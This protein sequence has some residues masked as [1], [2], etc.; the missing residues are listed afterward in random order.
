VCW[1]RSHFPR[2]TPTSAVAPRACQPGDMTEPRDAAR[3][4]SPA[5]HGCATPLQLFC[6]DLRLY[7][8]GCYHMATRFGLSQHHW[9]RLHQTE[10]ATVVQT[11]AC[12]RCHLRACMGAPVRQK[13]A[14]RASRVGR[15][16]RCLRLAGK[17]SCLKAFIAHIPS[18]ARDWNRTLRGRIR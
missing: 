5:Q 9:K 1:Q 2:L 6:T 14:I 12:H 11:C 7:C 15:P 17:V 16:P 3:L 10:S 18:Q 4:E 13:A 8:K